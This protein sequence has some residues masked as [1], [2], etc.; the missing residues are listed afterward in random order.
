[1]PKF[2][3]E[4][5]YLVP[6]YEQLIVE[7]DDLV[8]ACRRASDDG[9]IEWPET[10][11]TDYDSAGPT[12]ITEARAIPARKFRGADATALLYSCGLPAATIPA[13][14]REPERVP[15]ASALRALIAAA[16][17]GLAELEQ[18]LAQRETAGNG[19]ETGPLT[20]LCRALASALGM[21]R[22][23]LRWQEPRDQTSRT[24]IDGAALIERVLYVAPHD[25]PRTPG[26]VARGFNEARDFVVKT[27]EGM[28][29]ENKTK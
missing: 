3:I 8:T 18:E 6:V 2:A 29:E 17:D 14:F 22:G 23:D 5:Q 12:R 10:A 7:A 1:M 24:M 21:A 27:I 25:M 9:D 16:A 15:E 20:D 26:L 13:E 19:E 11:K 4:R 28:I